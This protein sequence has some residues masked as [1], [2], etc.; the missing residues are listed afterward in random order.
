MHQTKLGDLDTHFFK[1][2]IGEVISEVVSEV[3]WM[4]HKILV[5]AERCSSFPR[6]NEEEF[7]EGKFVSPDVTEELFPFVERKGVVQFEVGTTPFTWNS[8]AELIQGGKNLGLTLPSYQDAFLLFS[9]GWSPDFL[10]LG[11][12]ALYSESKPNLIIFPSDS[13]KP[14]LVLSRYSKEENEAMEKTRKPGWY[15][16]A[17]SHKELESL[18]YGSS[19]SGAVVVFIRTNLQGPCKTVPFFTNLPKY[20]ILSRMAE[21]KKILIIEDEKFLSMILK[22]RFEREGFNVF[23]AVDG[24]E[25]L[26]MAQE[27]PD[28]I[29]LDLIMPKVSGFE[30]LET[31]RTDP[32]L[33]K[34]PVVV[35]SNLGQ[36]SDIQKARELG[37]VDYYV[38]ATTPV[39]DIVKMVK[40]AF[41]MPEDV[42]MEVPEGT[43]AQEPAEAQSTEPVQP[44]EQIVQPDEPQPTGPVQ[45]G[46]PT[47]VPI[48]PAPIDP[49]Q[50]TGTIQ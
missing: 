30:V 10:A 38:K 9:S 28:I 16:E 47:E 1:R 45:P 15:L 36:E 48:D 39:E 31:M 8:I 22:S 25:G 42:Q 4:P 24:E 33:S 11:R 49:D 29:L 14:N 21:G 44:T 17:M 12:L 6:D 27:T 26:K 37:V 41:G 19:A 50:S 13:V 32:E 3:F 35:A 2:Y 34:I 23:Q 20:S 7:S 46:V 18:D 43:A 40:R 5:D